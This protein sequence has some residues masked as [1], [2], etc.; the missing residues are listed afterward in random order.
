MDELQQVGPEYEGPVA[1]EFGVWRDGE[2]FEIGLY[3]S[4]ESAQAAADYKTQMEPGASFRVKLFSRLALRDVAQM[5]TG[6]ASLP[7][8]IAQIITLSDLLAQAIGIEHV[9]NS[10][11]AAITDS[12][13]RLTHATQ[14]LADKDSEMAGR[15]RGVQ[16]S[17]SEILNA[18]DRGDRGDALAH[19]R[20]NVDNLF[21]ILSHGGDRDG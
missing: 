18:L 2:G 5:M 19:A 1:E 21:G 15:L 14:L 8:G 20:A 4:E 3:S 9:E 11:I 16:C 17:L 6:V 13:Q 10:S 7:D 12:V